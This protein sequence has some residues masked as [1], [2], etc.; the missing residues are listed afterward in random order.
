VLTPY[1]EFLKLTTHTHTRTLIYTVAVLYFRMS[2]D[3]F[4]LVWNEVQDYSR[5]K[6]HIF[7]GD[8]IGHCENKVNL[9]MCLILHG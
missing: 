5:L 4:A 9:N 7:G 2:H 1:V 6:A 3:L 8:S